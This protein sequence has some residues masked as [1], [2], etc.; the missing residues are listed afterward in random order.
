MSLSVTWLNSINTETNRNS[1]VNVYTL[2]QP[3]PAGSLK[4]MTMKP[5]KISRKIIQ[6]GIKHLS[7]L[8]A[9]LTYVE[10]PFL[11]KYAQDQQ[12]H[13]QAIWYNAGCHS[14]LSE[15][16]WFHNHYLT[17]GA[18]FFLR[19]LVKRFR[20]IIIVFEAVH[21]LPFFLSLVNAIHAVPLCNT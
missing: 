5:S 1:T 6:L 3:F 7:F 18:D 19:S 8:S 20:T 21:D 4:L 14:M 2:E 13:V 11:M 10:H 16:D 17:H 15:H 12:K 9:T